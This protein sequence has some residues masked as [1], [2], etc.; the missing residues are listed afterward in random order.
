MAL[1]I[2]ISICNLF[3][4]TPFLYTIV[5]YERFGSE[6]PRTLLNQLVA[7]TCWNGIIHNILFVPLSIFIDFFGKMSYRFCQFNFLLKNSTMSHL[8]LML[9][10]IIFVKYISIYKLKNPTELLNDF[11]CFYLNILFIFLAVVFQTAVTVLPGVNPIY[12]HICTGK[13][14]MKLKT[15]QGKINLPLLGIVVFGFVS[16]IC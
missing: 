6:H 13:N 10:V 8:L 12:F 11:W 2:A 7:S 16:F 3:A 14:P 4:L 5:W 1:G 15:G 9:A